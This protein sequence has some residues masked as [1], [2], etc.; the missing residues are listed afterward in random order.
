MAK[1][2]GLRVNGT[3][4]ML[5][6]GIRALDALPAL[7]AKLDTNDDP[8]EAAEAAEIRIYENMPIEA[9]IY[10]PLPQRGDHVLFQWDGETWIEV[11]R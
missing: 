6:E 11:E 5:Y 10:V 1:T 7:I 8:L 3:A 9:S 2:Q 4:A